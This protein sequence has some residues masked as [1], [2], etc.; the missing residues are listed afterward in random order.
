MVE[1]CPRLRCRCFCKQTS[2]LTKMSVSQASW[3]PAIQRS[4]GGSLGAR[5]GR[6]EQGE[7]C[8]VPFARK[9]CSGRLTVG[10][11]IFTLRH[12]FCCYL[13]HPP[14]L[15]TFSLSLSQVL[16]P[17][18]LLQALQSEGQS[19]ATLLPLG[20]RFLEERESDFILQQGGW[21]SEKLL[22][23][24][25]GMFAIKRLLIY[26]LLRIYLMQFNSIHF[27]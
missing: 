25:R 21:V 19:L 18:V 8:S 15:L 1:N 3:L 4:N 7:R 22:M 10:Q 26:C 16:V 6:L 17:L 20:V 11:G 24:L 13:L 23:S 5:T 9:P 14:H 12:G 2:R 27:T